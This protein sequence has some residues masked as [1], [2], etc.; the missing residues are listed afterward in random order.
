MKIKANF[1][2]GWPRQRAGAGTGAI[3]SYFIVSHAS[4][5]NGSPNTI[6]GPR[7]EISPRLSLVERET[8]NS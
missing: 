8:H 3:R 7:G 1:E 5:E 2:Y 6:K 4:S